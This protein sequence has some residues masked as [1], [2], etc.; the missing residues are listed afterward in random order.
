MC[1]IR[2]I[3][4]SETLSFM[5]YKNSLAHRLQLNTYIIL[6]QEML[7]ITQLFAIPKHEIISTNM[8]ESV[9]SAISAIDCFGCAGDINKKCISAA[10]N[11]THMFDK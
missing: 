4:I 9:L 7:R 11:I 8:I 1:L 3:D 5:H 6:R 10:R 2:S